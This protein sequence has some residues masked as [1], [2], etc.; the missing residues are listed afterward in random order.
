MMRVPRG[1]SLVANRPKPLP[2]ATTISKSGSIRVVSN[3]SI[4]QGKIITPSVSFLSVSAVGFLSCCAGAVSLLLVDVLT[5]GPLT[6]SR[7]RISVTSSP[8]MVVSGVGD[9]DG[10]PWRTLCRQS[11]DVPSGPVQRENPKQTE[12]NV[13]KEK[14]KYR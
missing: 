7:P 6:L 9:F 14:G 10:L 12:M 2:G 5:P 13:S 1:M 4:D 3:G 11:S 8:A